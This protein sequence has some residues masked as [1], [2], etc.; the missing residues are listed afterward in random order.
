MT[1]KE[2]SCVVVNVSVMISSGQQSLASSVV[3]YPIVHLLS[4]LYAIRL[5]P[6]VA[7]ETMYINGT[8]SIM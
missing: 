7:S 8:S 1:M 2:T 3:T 4:L 6:V 5:E